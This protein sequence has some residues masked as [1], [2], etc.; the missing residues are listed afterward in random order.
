[1]FFIVEYG[2]TATES[3]RFNKINH[4][5]SLIMDNL[6]KGIDER[7]NISACFINKEGHKCH[8]AFLSIRN[9]P[10]LSY[11]LSNQWE[12]IPT[13]RIGPPYLYMKKQNSAEFNKLNGVLS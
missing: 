9:T 11:Q 12:V 1:M 2:T 13:N 4:A 5:I 6:R 3:P 8:I 10:I 7:Y